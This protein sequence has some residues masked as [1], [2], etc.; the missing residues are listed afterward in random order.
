MSVSDMIVTSASRVRGERRCSRGG[1]EM[2][3]VA[4]DAGRRAPLRPTSR[5]VVISLPSN[6]QQRFCVSSIG[7]PGTVAIILSM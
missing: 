6:D 5:H 1:R 3:M 2:V 4:F 7:T